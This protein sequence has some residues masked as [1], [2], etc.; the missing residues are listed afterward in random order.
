MHELLLVFTLLI[1]KHF[2]VDF[3]LQT[4]YQWSNKGTYAHPG[5]ILH[6]GLHGIGTY[7]C[8]FWYA[9]VA[10]VY[11]AF[12]DMFIHY[13]IDWAKMNINSK[14]GWGPNTHDEFWWLLGLDQFLHYLTYV[15]I[16]WCIF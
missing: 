13:H 10:A 8:L 1:V 14:M 15:A 7:V 6:A 4:K 5:G 12:A 16:L 3:P 2:I 9:P 11:L